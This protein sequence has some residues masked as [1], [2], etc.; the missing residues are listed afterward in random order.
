[1]IDSH[2]DAHT[3]GL[4]ERIRRLELELRLPTAGSVH[5]R[6]LF[7]RMLV[8]EKRNLQKMIHELALNKQYS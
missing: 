8:I 3:K 2:I 7:I 5:H 1:M 6:S 4:E